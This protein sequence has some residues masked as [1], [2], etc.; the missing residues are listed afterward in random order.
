MILTFSAV[1][2]EVIM[3]VI[4]MLN[5][6][7]PTMQGIRYSRCDD[8]TLMASWAGGDHWRNPPW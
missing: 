6:D 7:V 8:R 3:L 4:I 1:L 2:V 5:S